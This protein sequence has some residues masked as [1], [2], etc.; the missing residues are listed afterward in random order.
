M[1]DR[2][3]PEENARCHTLL[4]RIVLDILLLI[5]LLNTGLLGVGLDASQTIGLRKDHRLAGC[6]SS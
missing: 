2:S 5:L 4:I 1:L 3:S 6:S